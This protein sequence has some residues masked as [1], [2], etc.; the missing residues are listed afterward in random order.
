MKKTVADASRKRKIDH[1]KFPPFSQ[2][3]EIH[4]ENKSLRKILCK[5]RRKT[6]SPPSS[7]IQQFSNNINGM[8]HNFFPLLLNKICWMDISDFSWLVFDRK[9][10]SVVLSFVW[11][12]ETCKLYINIQLSKSNTFLLFSENEV[13]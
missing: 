9:Y 5:Y 12:F 8:I 4:C 11:Y 3:L 2:F 7:T 6:V 1:S 13:N 10:Q